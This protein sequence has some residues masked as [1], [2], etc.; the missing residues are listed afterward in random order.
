MDKTASPDSTTIDVLHML[1]LLQGAMLLLSGLMMFVFS[2]ASPLALPLTI[3]VPLLLFVLAAGTVRRWR[4]V[5]RVT[6]VVQTL[7]LL[8]FA[9][10]FLLGLLAALDFSLNLLTLITN[11]VLPVSVIALARRMPRAVAAVAAVEEP[12]RAAA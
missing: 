6:M 7:T 10:S 3:G 12:A 11:V 9:L 1:L 4:W 2:G 8:A 5:R